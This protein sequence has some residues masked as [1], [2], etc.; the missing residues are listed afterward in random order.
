MFVRQ[1]S[2]DLWSVAICVWTGGCFIVLLPIVV[3]MGYLVKIRRAARSLPDSVS[4]SMVEGLFTELGIQCRIV[5][6]GN[7]ILLMTVTWGLPRPVILVPTGVSEWSEE[8]CRLVLLHEMASIKRFDWFTHLER[9]QV[10]DDLVVAAGTQP[11]DYAD[12]LV[13]MAKVLKVRSWMTRVAVPIARH[14]KIGTPRCRN[15]KNM[16]TT[17]RR[18]RS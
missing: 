15:F 11:C 10:C 12:K 16:A 7:G 3:G 5:L 6:L 9:E 13:E 18:L 1:F 2:L 17:S 8:P 14:S 4:L